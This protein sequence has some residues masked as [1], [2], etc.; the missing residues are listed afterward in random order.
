MY[1]LFYVYSCFKNHNMSM[2]NRYRYEV[3]QHIFMLVILHILI[4]AYIPSTYFINRYNLYNCL[5]QNNNLKS[6]YNH[7]NRKNEP[8]YDDFLYQ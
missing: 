7:Y 2:Y 4:L 6:R 8:L 3:H 5:Y 1:I